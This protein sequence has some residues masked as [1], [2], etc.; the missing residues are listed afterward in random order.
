[1]E[2][3]DTVRPLCPVFEARNAKRAPTALHGDC[4]RGFEIKIE[5]KTFDEVKND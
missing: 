4:K 3:R 2:P 5:Q 1:M